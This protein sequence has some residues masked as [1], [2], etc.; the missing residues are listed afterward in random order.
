MMILVGVTFF[1]GVTLVF[2]WGGGGARGGGVLFCGF[3]RRGKGG[4]V[5]GEFGEVGVLCF[6]GWGGWG[7]FALL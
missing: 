4:V 2:F 1:W 6:G 3:G 7:D 5:D